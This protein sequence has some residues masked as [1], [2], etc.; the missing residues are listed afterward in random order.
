MEKLKYDALSDYDK[1]ILHCA[2]PH[3]L[4]GAKHTVEGI[5]ESL[6]SQVK[7]CVDGGRPADAERLVE[8]ANIMESRLRS[9]DTTKNTEK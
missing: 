6:L 7:K 3:V 1:Y 5:K 2:M 4:F 8:A 9:E